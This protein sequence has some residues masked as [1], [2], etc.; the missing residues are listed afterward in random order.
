MRKVYAKPSFDVELF[1]T[2][3]IL[4]VSGENA[5]S[6]QI[7]NGVLTLENGTQINISDGNVL[8]SMDYKSFVKKQ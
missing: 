6:E 5:F 2:E 8:Q 7:K 3:D 4:L 1:R